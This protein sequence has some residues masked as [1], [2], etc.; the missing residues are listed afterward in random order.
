M[1]APWRKVSTERKGDLLAF[2]CGGLVAL[3]L[4]VLLSYVR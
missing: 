3:V 1:I 2:A 4:I